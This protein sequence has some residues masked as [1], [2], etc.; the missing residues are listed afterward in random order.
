MPEAKRTNYREVITVRGLWLSY[1]F[2]NDREHNN[3]NKHLT[4]IIFGRQ[5]DN[6][7]LVSLTKI[8]EGLCCNCVVV[9]SYK[10]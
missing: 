3:A 1:E 7:H 2:M 10:L 9:K 8:E 5:T 6:Y 4:G